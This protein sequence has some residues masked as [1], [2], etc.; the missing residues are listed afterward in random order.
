MQPQS[1]AGL[2]L[3][4]AGVLALMIR[5]FTYFTTEHVTGPLGFFAWEVE[6]PHTILINPIAGLLAIAL[7]VGLVLMSGRRVAA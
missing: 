3:I 4:V 6:Q 7:G 5:S 2:F 1:I